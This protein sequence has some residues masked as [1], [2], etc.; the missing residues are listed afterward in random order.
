MGP[1]RLRHVRHRQVN[2]TQEAQ[3]QG[4]ALDPAGSFYDL[5]LDHY[6]YHQTNQPE[7]MTPTPKVAS[8]TSSP[9]RITR[10]L[11]S[12]SWHPGSSVTH[13]PCMNILGVN[14]NIKWTS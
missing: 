9:S 14:P 1:H 6:F 3:E 7:Q 8:G 5:F 11:S 12:D 4:E 10:P 2:L 13:S